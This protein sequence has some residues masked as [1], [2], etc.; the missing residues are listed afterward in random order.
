[1]SKTAKVRPSTEIRPPEEHPMW[2]WV[3]IAAVAVAVLIALV[4]VLMML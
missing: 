2:P 4:N 3:V 1:M